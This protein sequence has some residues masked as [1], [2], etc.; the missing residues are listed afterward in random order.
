MPNQGHEARVFTAFQASVNAIQWAPEQLG[1]ILACASSDGKVS[2]LKAGISGQGGNE[3]WRQQVFLA[4]QMGA[5]CLSWE[6]VEES[7][8]NGT[9][10][11]SI[12]TP[13]LVT[14]GS[15]N[16]VKI[17]SRNEQGRVDPAAHPPLTPGLGEGCGMGTEEGTACFLLSRQSSPPLVT[18]LK[19]TGGGM[20]MPNHCHPLPSL[21]PSGESVGPWKVVTCWLSVVV[22]IKSHCG[23]RGRMENGSV[24][25]SMCLVVTAA[26]TTQ[27]KFINTN[28]KMHISFSFFIPKMHLFCSST[29]DAP[30][31][32]PVASSY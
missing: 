26:L 18:F 21:T 27:H 25:V 6:P 3:E 23:Q 28:N 11:T 4:H 5:L 19:G 12:T 13:R 24:S 22:T 2:I 10:S 14:G 8:N 17:W 29:P 32:L 7:T 16:A 15:D 20:D 1:P 9:H 31:W 30:L